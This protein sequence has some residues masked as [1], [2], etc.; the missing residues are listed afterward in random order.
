MFFKQNK[1]V[2]IIL[3]NQIQRACSVFEPSVYHIIL[4]FI[5]GPFLVLPIQQDDSN[6]L[7]EVIFWAYNILDHICDQGQHLQTFLELDFL[8]FIEKPY[9]F[10]PVQLVNLRLSFK[11][12][13][14]YSLCLSWVVF[15]APVI[16]ASLLMRRSRLVVPLIK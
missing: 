9:G 12:F 2:K 15:V 8:Q 14:H 10:D 3:Q 11:E 5:D 1:Y 13:V 7:L 6:V 16:H 4:A